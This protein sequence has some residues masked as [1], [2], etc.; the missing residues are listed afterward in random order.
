MGPGKHGTLLH[1]IL[2][3]LIL[4]EFRIVNK[5]FSNN[6]FSN[7]ATGYANWYSKRTL[8]PLFVGSTLTPVAGLLKQPVCLNS[9]H[10]TYPNTICIWV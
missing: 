10:F 4:Q 8:T 3:N 1:A 5:I 2:Y 6:I 9:Y 7:R